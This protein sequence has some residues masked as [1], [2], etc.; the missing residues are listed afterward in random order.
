[1]TRRL[2]IVANRLPVHLTSDNE[3]RPSAG[4]LVSA[5]NSYLCPTSGLNTSEFDETD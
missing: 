3:L 2:F 1:M 4:G 5:I